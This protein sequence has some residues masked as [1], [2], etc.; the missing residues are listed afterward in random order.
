M[1]Q[2]P[3]YKRPLATVLADLRY[4]KPYLV[5][6]RGQRTFRIEHVSEYARR[7]EKSGSP[8]TRRYLSAFDF[9][10]DEDPDGKVVVMSDTPKGPRPLAA[11]YGSRYT[12][13][14]LDNEG[15]LGRE[16]VLS[17]SLGKVDSCEGAVYE[18]RCFIQDSIYSF[19][20]LPSH[21]QKDALRQGADFEA[22]FGH[23]PE[24]MR[25]R[26]LMVPHAEV[27]RLLEQQYGAELANK[28]RSEPIRKL[29]QSIER[30]GL[31]YPAVADEGWKR[32]LA[33]ASL[34]RDLPYFEVL[35]P[36]DMPFDPMI[37]TLDGNR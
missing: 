1:P 13:W 18:R 33:I 14:T 37:P 36:F 17:G 7:E 20:D 31:Q 34:G 5:L 11:E 29:A 23:G 26:F 30:E 4:L 10:W 22:H 24:S 2:G 9:W 15:D 8:A 25:F 35:E 3:N 32:A 28:M 19:Y 12:A 16:M 21:S 27:M 6:V